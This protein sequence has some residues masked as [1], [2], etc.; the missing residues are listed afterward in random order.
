MTVA[1]LSHLAFTL[2]YHAMGA[3]QG[4]YSSVV[5]DTCLYEIFVLID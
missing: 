4:L 5:A 3:M 1:V 2:V